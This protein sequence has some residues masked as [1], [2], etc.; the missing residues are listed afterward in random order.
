M[1]NQNKYLFDSNVI[2]DYLRG[3]ERAV[4]LIEK[5]ELLTI[6]VVT[7]GEVY[8][9]VL[10]NKELQRIREVLK[11]FKVINI[12]ESISKNAVKLVENYHL[13]SGL[14]FL[15]ALIAATALE[16][17][18]TLLT[19]NTKHFLKIKEIRVEKW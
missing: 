7:V 14:Y 5:T 1:Q 15:D 3:N 8:Q 2:I 11:S 13:T 17:N 4:S 18:L 19:S 9:G 10:N 6:S 16:N 12:I